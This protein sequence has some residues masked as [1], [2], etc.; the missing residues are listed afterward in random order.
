MQLN[1]S[2]PPDNGQTN[3]TTNPIQLKNYIFSYSS[4]TKTDCRLYW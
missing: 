1:A 3:T 2:R 4:N